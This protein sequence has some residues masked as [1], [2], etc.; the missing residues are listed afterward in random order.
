[1][2][3]KYKILLLSLAIMLCLSIVAG[4][5]YSLWSSTYTQ[6]T[7]NKIAI[8][9]FTIDFSEAGTNI[10]LANTYP[11][12]DAKGLAKTPYTFTVSNTC[13]I[14]S[15]TNIA[16]DVLNTSTMS[17]GYIKAAIKEGSGNAVVK[18]L[19]N[20]LSAGTIAS[21]DTETKESWILDTITLKPNETKT[22]SIYMWVGE[23]INNDAQGKTLNAKINVSDYAAKTL[24]YTD[25]TG[26]NQPELYQGL[27]P[28]KYDA[29]GNTV[30]AD[31]YQE[32]YNYASHNWANA[33]LVNCADATI[34]AKY[35]N[36]DMSLKTSAIGTTM[37]DTDILQYYVWIPR[38]K[39]LLWNAE[40]G[41]S[42]PQAI[43]ITFERTTDTK[44]TGSTNGTWLTHPAFTFGTTE[45]PGLWV[46]KFETSGTETTLTIKPHITSLRG[47]SLGAMFNATR[48]IELTYASNFGISSSQIDTHVIKNMDW[49]AVAYLSSSIYGRYTD[50]TTCISSGCE[51]W[52]N[53][54]NVF[55]TGCAGTSVIASMGSTCN[56]WNSILGANAS[57]SGTQYGI[58][59]MSG[60][61]WD[62]VMGT[63]QSSTGTFYS[64][65][66]SMPTVDSKYYDSYPYGT[67]EY[68]F[69]RSKLG[70]ATKEIIKTANT[71]YGSWYSN[72]SSM[73][74]PGVEEGYWYMRGG[75]SVYNGTIE[76]IYT[77][78]TFFDNAYI[79]GS[80]RSVLTAE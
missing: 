42:D 6:S 1:M 37:T 56:A 68:D 45:L 60:G 52:N 69:S 47:I 61:A 33:V 20:T 79:Y 35:F 62:Y 24:T 63:M 27:I 41:S 50:S 39:Y 64:G 3:K 71:S 5:S 75:A 38:Y 28:V 10:N 4:T 17:S 53:P 54:S 46:G 76:G 18:G 58:Y 22:Y 44:S 16:V 19:L 12:S 21:G 55:L 74:A 59:D 48:N 26:A 51:V 73:L 32:W 49:G 77:F 80:F 25:G 23:T 43:S 40:N 70:D 13:T 34:K 67:N 8:G 72:Y 57:T 9:C 7:S 36:D 31:T 15:Q 14:T 29:S 78:Y 11:I 2:A 66:S 30:V 65:S